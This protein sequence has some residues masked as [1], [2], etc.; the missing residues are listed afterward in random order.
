MVRLMS[1]SKASPDAACVIYTR[2]TDEANKQRNISAVIRKVWQRNLTCASVRA[3]GAEMRRTVEQTNTGLSE[4]ASLIVVQGERRKEGT[5]IHSLIKDRVCNERSQCRKHR[6][7]DN[8][9]EDH[10][11]Y[12]RSKHRLDLALSSLVITVAA[13]TTSTV[14]SLC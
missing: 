3:G 5:E 9:R 4:P 1:R 6:Q 7:D 12:H 8:W 11:R 10:P 13:A 14:P 2:A